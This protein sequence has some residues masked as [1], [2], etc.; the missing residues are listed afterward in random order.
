MQALIAEGVVTRDT[1]RFVQARDG[2]ALVQVNL[3]GRVSTESAA[4]VVVNKWLEVRLSGGREEVRTSEYSYHAFMHTR[5][6]PRV[7]LFR[8]DNCH[9]GLDTLHCHRFAD[10][11]SELPSPTDIEHALLPPLSEIVREADT[12]A[13]ALTARLR[14]N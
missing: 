9:G 8:Y 7:D 3:R 1:L 5:R 12:C 14:A 13:A 10:D 4:I 11:G 2:H 6:L